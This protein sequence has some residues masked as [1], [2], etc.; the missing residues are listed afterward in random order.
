M[1]KYCPK[2]FKKCPS[3]VE[4]CP[5]DGSFLVSPHEKDLT[6]EVLDNRYPHDKILAVECVS[7]PACFCAFMKAG[8]RATTHANGRQAELRR[9][10]PTLEPGRDVRNYHGSGGYE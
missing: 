3:S 5:A 7:V 4:V 2:C 9:L 6:G 1:E 10:A 8:R